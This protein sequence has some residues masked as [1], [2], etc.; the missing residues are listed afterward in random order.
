MVKLNALN[1]KIC[2]TLLALLVTIASD[3]TGN[4]PHSLEHQDSIHFGSTYDAQHTQASPCHDHSTRS[5]SCSTDHCNLCATF[6]IA[7]QTLLSFKLDNSI[8]PQALSTQPPLASAFG[9]Y[10][11]PRAPYFT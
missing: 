4:I 8:H 3:A 1:V 2:L 6:L 11:P 7:D 10:R 9:I 5:D